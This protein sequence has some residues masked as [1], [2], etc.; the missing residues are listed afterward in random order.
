MLLT[1]F[2]CKSTRHLKNSGQFSF[3]SSNWL[4]IWCSLILENF[5]KMSEMGLVF[6]RQCL[7]PLMNGP[8]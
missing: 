3:I 4:L 1:E 5:L 7:H 8:R 2:M 6:N